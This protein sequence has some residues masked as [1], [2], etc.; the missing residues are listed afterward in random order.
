M[1]TTP[2]FVTRTDDASGD[3]FLT[4]DAPSGDKAQGVVIIDQNGDQAGITG[5]PIVVSV[6]GSVTVT[7]TV[8]ANIGTQA[9]PLTIDD[10]TPID[11]A[12]TGTPIPVS[13]SSGTLVQYATGGSAEASAVVVASAAALREL[14]VVLD[15]SAT[16][17]RYMMLFN[18]TSLPVN[19]TAPAWRGLVPPSG[20]MSENWPDGLD[21][22]TGIV[23]ALSETADTLTVAPAEAFFHAVRI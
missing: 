6:S 8:T 2:T 4:F 7:G 12:I 5:T 21:F 15:P 10:S 17:L 1:A 18:A 9:A 13:F 20:E 19:G 11:V 14:R 16:T 3:Q 22:A 23:V